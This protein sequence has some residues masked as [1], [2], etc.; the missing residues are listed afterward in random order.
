MNQTTIFSSLKKSNSN[1]FLIIQSFFA[2]WAMMRIGNLH[3]MN[4]F[5]FLLFLFCFLSFSV[6]EK[7]TTIQKHSD[8]K[9]KQGLSCLLS[10]LFTIFY[11]AGSYQNL[12]QDL[13][14]ALFQMIILSVTFIGLYFVFYKA[15][16]YLNCMLD[17]FELP[18]SV[19]SIKLISCLPI[20]CFVFCILCRIPFL[21]YSYPGIMTPDS[22]NQFE[23]VLGM[24]PFS[25][26]HPWIHTMTIS[27]FYHIGTLFT[28]SVNG[29]F[30]FYTIFQICFMAFAA[31]YLIWIV[32]KYTSSLYLPVGIILFYAFMSYHNVMAIC[33]WKDI[34]FS[35]C[36]LIFCTSLF[37]LFREGIGK[38]TWFSLIMYLLSGILVCLYRSN[39]WYAFLITLPFLLFCFRKQWKIMYPVHLFILCFVLLIKGPVMEHYDVTQPDFV[40]SIS[41]PLQQVC[42]VIVEGKELTLE[43]EELI[44]KVID[45]TYIDQLY[46]ESFSDNMKELVRAGNPD[47]LTSHKGQYLKLWVELG[48]TYPEVY[49]EAYIGQTKGYYSPSEIYPVADVEGVI[50]NNTGLQGE[51]LIRGK[52]LVKVREILLKLQNMIPLY[53]AFWSMGSLF[54]MTLLCLIFSLGKKKSSEASQLQNICRTIT[55]WIPNLAV[56]ATLLLATPVAS[57]FRYAYNLAYCIPLYFAIMCILR[58]EASKN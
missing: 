1:L 58:S 38:A 10:G 47:Y 31:S 52:L 29:A 12:I 56:I 13:S 42:R 16:L 55:V 46:V 6:I 17:Y 54:W 45:T 50:A 8:L 51:F 11:L 5:G 25:N 37:H 39:G 32:S 4:I 2:S 34:L 19:V 44:H 48:L 28:S 41:V 53:G 35:G 9:K 40:E 30:V 33:I 3:S 21:L 14:N 24:Q 36:L 18:K 57:E 20:F 26:H 27:L 22:I 49:L 43:Q 23:Q 7:E 15:I